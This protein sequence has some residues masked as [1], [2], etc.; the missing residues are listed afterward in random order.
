MQEF[1][2]QTIYGKLTVIKLLFI[3]LLSTCIVLN[4][5]PAYALG[6][7]LIIGLFAY[8]PYI[9][10]TK[11]YTKYLLQIS[12]VGLGFAMDIN[13]VLK[14]GQSGILYT[15][16]TI[17]TTLA[18][19]TILGKL[20]K[21]NT[22]TSYLVSSGTAICG[23]SAIAAVSPVIKANDQQ[24]SV[25]IGTVFILNAVAL[26]IFPPIG[27][28]LGLTQQQFGIW[29]AIAIHDTSSVVGAAKQY[30]DEALNI[31]TTVKLA[32]ALWIVPLVFATSFIFKNE[33]KKVSF[34]LFILFFI[35]ASILKTY[36][37]MVANN[38]KELVVVAKVG[39]SVTLY[40]IGAGISLKAM[41]EIGPRPLLQGVILWAFVMATSL[42]VVW[43][44]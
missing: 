23:G 35:A 44:M 14:A 8:N 12:V 3:S 11:K 13:E 18:A 33:K 26:F 31:A 16:I 22:V 7:G 4:L 29:C 2:N 42:Y 40:F 6:L 1:L 28:Y 5:P 30:G 9:H 43:K 15:S 36:I 27:H 25:S 24:I 37:P 38:A 21:V 34:P 41:K 20:L 17:I 32:R 39:L 19:G 10:L